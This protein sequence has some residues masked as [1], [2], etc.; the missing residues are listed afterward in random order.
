MVVLLQ[1]L[2]WAAKFYDKHLTRSHELNA[3][4][5]ATTAA[6]GVL[7]ENHNMSDVA[8]GRALIAEAGQFVSPALPFRPNFWQQGIRAL[9]R[10]LHFA[11]AYWIMLMAMYYNGFVIICIILGAFI[12]IFVFQWDRLGGTCGASPE[13]AVSTD[14]TGCCG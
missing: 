2:G 14:A 1:A 10:T 13:G 7:T 8:Q 6:E 9:I 4:S 5:V 11:L 3:V 12:G